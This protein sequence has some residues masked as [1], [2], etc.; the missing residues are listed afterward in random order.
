MFSA[1]LRDILLSALG[2]VRNEQQLTDALRRLEAFEAERELNCRENAHLLLGRAML[3][4]ARARK[5]SRGAH[6][7]E[8]FPK[9]EDEYMKKSVAVCDGGSVSVSFASPDSYM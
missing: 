2:I 1:Q 6:F 8:D 7:R 4:S 3:L 5:E 9:T